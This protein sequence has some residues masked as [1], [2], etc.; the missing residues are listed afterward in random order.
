MPCCDYEP[1]LTV[2]Y[3]QQP[4]TVFL[5]RSLRG[6]C[7]TRT[8]T[9]IGGTGWGDSREKGR[10]RE[11]I[12]LDDLNTCIKTIM[13]PQCQNATSQFSV[14]LL[15][16]PVWS[17]NSCGFVRVVFQEPPEPFTTLNRPLALRVLT[18]RRKEEHVA[19]TLVIPLVMK[20][21]HILR[22]HMAE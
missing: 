15:H 14:P 18:D 4:S 13:S 1:S 7:N 10:Y 2:G 9:A 3:P 8:T 11:T 12:A 19:F 17:K 22:Q 16:K 20:M 5:I 21:R 6:P